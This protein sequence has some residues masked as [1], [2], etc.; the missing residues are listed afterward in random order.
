MT[1]YKKLAC[2]CGHLFDMHVSK[3]NSCFCESYDA[4]GHNP[5]IEN[6]ICPQCNLV[7]MEKRLDT[8]ICYACDNVLF[9]K[10]VRQIVG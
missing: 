5:E 9:E 10:Q 4:A 1:F 7:R 8:Y 2:I 6:I 3:C